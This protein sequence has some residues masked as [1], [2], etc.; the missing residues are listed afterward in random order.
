MLNNRLGEAFTDQP[1][2]NDDIIRR[3]G[4]ASIS[5][6][7]TTKKVGD[8]MRD[9]KLERKYYFDREGR[10]IKAHETIQAETGKDT[11]V[12]YWE[13]DGR[14]N[15]VVIRKADQYGFYATH[16]EYDEKNRVVRE[17]FRR[18]LNQ[19]KNRIGFLLSEEYV[20]TFETSRYE[21][22]EGQEKRIFINSYDYP[23]KEEITY[24]DEDGVITE[25]MDR[26]KRTS[27]IK[28]TRYVYNEK[29]LL[30]SLVIV[31]NQTGSAERTFTYEYD[32]YGNL[33]SKQY[34]NNSIHQTDYQII[35]HRET[36]L[37][38]Y[39]LTREV[40]TNFITV[41]KLNNYTFYDKGEQRLE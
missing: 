24:F 13:Y 21:N 23:Y 10:L 9:T 16:F 6:N 34:Y 8:V 11:L 37:V 2:F 19:N 15:L 35:Y 38:N 31:S 1:F 27:G 40:I 17:E 29:G 12:T 3:N 20:V 30:D 32:Q 7:F 4:I 41:L 14:G 26:L 36:S 5:G 28:R 33:L 25:R 39:I 22:Y 18:N